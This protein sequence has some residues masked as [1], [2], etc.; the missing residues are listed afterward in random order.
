MAQ[1]GS[2]TSP[3]R[4]VARKEPHQ[5][6]TIMR[7]AP[8]TTSFSRVK[9]AIGA[10]TAGPATKK[11]P[12]GGV[13]GI[14]ASL[15]LK[16]KSRRAFLFFAKRRP[17]AASAGLIRSIPA[18]GSSGSPFSLVGLIIIAVSSILRIIL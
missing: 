10:P 8:S 6:Y 15:L 5:P 1:V 18:A 17:A 14:S 12:D 3:I 9:T 2:S 7:R 11:D 16:R 13:A 4:N